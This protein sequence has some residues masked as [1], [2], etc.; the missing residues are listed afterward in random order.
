MFSI[1]LIEKWCR[2]TYFQGSDRDTDVEN[3][4]VDLEGAGR[5]DWESSIDEYRLPC[6][7]QQE[8]AVQHSQL[9]A[10]GGPPGWDEGVEGGSRREGICVLLQ[11]IHVVLQQKL[12]RHCRAIILQLK[13]KLRCS[14]LFLALCFL[15]FAE[16]ELLWFVHSQWY[17]RALTE[18]FMIQH[19]ID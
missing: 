2:W 7:K 11:L 4:C 5:M 1:L 10:L 6:G 15:S 17:L 18:G 19:S 9:H 13:K 8:A 14:S 3:R 16:K 12:T